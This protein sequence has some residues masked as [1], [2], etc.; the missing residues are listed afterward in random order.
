MSP[1]VGEPAAEF[2]LREGM[3]KSKAPTTLTGAV[4]CA[5]TLGLAC[6]GGATDQAVASSSDGGSGSDDA[7]SINAEFQLPSGT[8][9]IA[10]YNL[11]GPNDF[12]R[13]DMWDFSGS[14]AVGF[15]IDNV[16]PGNGYTLTVTASSGDGGEVCSGSASINVAAQTIV[17]VSVTAQCTGA[18]FVPSGYGSLDVWA[19]L[20]KGVSF[21]GAQF[22]LTGPGGVEDQDTVAVNGTGLHFTLQQVPAGSGQMLTLTAVSSDGSERCTASSMFDI[23]ANQTSETMLSPQCQ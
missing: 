12:S 14:Q 21:T 15:L 1:T 23:L 7:G 4:T 10:S 13:S 5:L 9:S 2:G 18:P 6:C 11:T 3:H 8:A 19:T 20:P 22:V 17:P 16:P